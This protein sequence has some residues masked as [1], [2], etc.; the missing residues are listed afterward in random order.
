MK[1]L[2][3]DIFGKLECL[4]C[5]LE[6]IT[7][8]LWYVYEDYYG[9]GNKDIY[10]KANFYDRIGTYLINIHSLLFL[11]QKEINEFIEK[12]YKEK[13]T[14]KENTNKW[15]IQILKQRYSMIKKRMRFIKFQFILV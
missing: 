15:K 8:M 2:E 10:T 4:S 6:E 3:K 9:I 13:K 1:R 14:E 5:E 11:K 7:E 12:V